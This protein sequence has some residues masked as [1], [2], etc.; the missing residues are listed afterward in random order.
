MEI[1][2][3]VTRNNFIREAITS[4]NLK[5]NRGPYHYNVYPKTENNIVDDIDNKKSIMTDTLAKI[6]Y[7]KNPKY[8]YLSLGFYYSLIEKIRTNL[9]IGHLL[10]RDIHIIIKGANAYMYLTK[11]IQNFPC[12][13]L[14]IMIYINP[15]LKDD[16]FNNIKQELKRL[17][18]QNLS[19]YKRLLDNMFFIGNSNAFKESEMY[20]Q[21]RLFSDDLI[22]SFKEDYNKEVDNLNTK[23]NQLIISPFESD[24][25]RNSCS[26]YSFML[27]NHQDP[28]SIV[29]IELPHFDKCENIPLKK[30]PFFCSANETIEFMRD[31]QNL[32]GKFDLY[33]IRFNNLF[34]EFNEDGKVA[35]EERIP[36]D[37]IDVSISSKSDAELLDFYKLA[38]CEHILDHDVSS[39]PILR[40]GNWEKVNCWLVMPNIKSC[41]NDLYKMLNVYECPEN[42]R[43][44]RELRYKAL[45]AYT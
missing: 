16:E 18:L 1:W 24:E 4:T 30:T 19:Q 35:R 27:T 5:N 33:R 36:A 20:K 28:K 22:Q 7:T 15:H 38:R 25:I 40:D 9:N 13:D 26:R 17:V 11:D 42:K 2:T 8:K 21:S 6:I 14:D 44:K 10:W 37:F 41:V 31:G 45:L 29:K 23:K 3:P 43:N 39:W 32:E 12:S 34:V